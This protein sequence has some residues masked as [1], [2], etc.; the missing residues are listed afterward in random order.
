MSAAAPDHDN[1]GARAMTQR[2][3][4][5]WWE[6]LPWLLALAIGAWVGGFDVLYACQD[7]AFDRAHGLRSIPVRFGIARSLAGSGRGESARP[8]SASSPRTCSAIAIEPDS[9]VERMPPRHTVRS[10]GRNAS[11]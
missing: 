5:R 3:K 10:S 8:A 1:L 4:L 2:H 9:P 6:P 7:V 11:W